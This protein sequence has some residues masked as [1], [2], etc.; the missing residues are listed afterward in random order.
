MLRS[1]LL[2]LLAYPVNKIKRS[3]KIYRVFLASLLHSKLPLR[4]QFSLFYDFHGPVT[5][6]Y[7]FDYFLVYYRRRYFF[8]FYYI[9]VWYVYVVLFLIWYTFLLQLLVVFWNLNKRGVFGV[10]WLFMYFLHRYQ[11]YYYW[12][13]RGYYLYTFKM[14]LK[15]KM[16]FFMQETAISFIFSQSLFVSTCR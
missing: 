5:R 16:L 2:K 7:R 6:K 10:H 3:F 4:A 15:R 14:F 13:R 8:S 9:F 12:T 1:C 11:L